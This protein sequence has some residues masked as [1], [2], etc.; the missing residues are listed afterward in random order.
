MRV[1]NIYKYTIRQCSDK[2]QNNAKLG[3]TFRDG[4]TNG[5]R[6]NEKRG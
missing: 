1:G 5:T 4:R 2:Y 6:R 3:L